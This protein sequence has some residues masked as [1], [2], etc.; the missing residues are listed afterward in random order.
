MTHF[1]G[2][3]VRMTQK[4]V[5]GMVF[6]T[7]FLAIFGHLFWPVFVTSKRVKS[8]WFGPF[9]GPPFWTPFLTQN[10]DKKGSKNGPKNDPQKWPIF[11]PFSGPI[12]EIIYASNACI[13]ENRRFWGHFCQ[14]ATCAKSRGLE[15]GDT[16]IDKSWQVLIKFCSIFQ[17]PWN[18]LRQK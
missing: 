8:R 14:V 18:N 10:R 2:R 11:G 3:I 7:L 17:K 13:F 12:F 15:F 5:I 9:F 16:K 6:R 1:S 4:W